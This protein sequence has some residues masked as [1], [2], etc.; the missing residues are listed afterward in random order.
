MV[1]GLIGTYGE[2]FHSSLSGLLPASLPL[3]SCLRDPLDAASTRLSPSNTPIGR[4]SLFPASSPTTVRQRWIA[5]RACARLVRVAGY[6]EQPRGRTCR[7]GARCP[8]RRCPESISGGTVAHVS[9]GKRSS[10]GRRAV[11]G[12]GLMEAAFV[13]G[14]SA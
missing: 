11:E 7:A 8:R 9:G 1:W 10:R 14:S 13:S 12:V 6:T 5:G 3:E 2:L 4:L